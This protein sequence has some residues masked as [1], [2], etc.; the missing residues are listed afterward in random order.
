MLESKCGLAERIFRLGLN[1]NNFPVIITYS[2]MFS[3][4]DTLKI[5]PFITGL[6]KCSF[7]V[8]LRPNESQI[9]YGGFPYV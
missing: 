2:L 6:T 5:Y 8:P 1:F 3:R 4:V 7:S 9:L